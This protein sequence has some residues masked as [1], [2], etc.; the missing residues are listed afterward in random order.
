MRIK[1]ATAAWSP[2]IQRKASTWRATAGIAG[3]A[4]F[5]ETSGAFAAE[6][7][8]AVLA[9]PDAHALSLRW[10]SLGR[11]GKN[12]TVLEPQPQCQADGLGNHQQGI[13]FDEVLHGK[14]RTLQPPV[15]AQH[16]ETGPKC[17]VTRIALEK[18]RS[19]RLFPAGGILDG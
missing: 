10:P 5:A 6:P 17:I 2:A 12:K 11:R 16:P 9:L 8:A 7:P 1:Y 13:A 18:H 19:A 4:A 3:R 15:A 14:C